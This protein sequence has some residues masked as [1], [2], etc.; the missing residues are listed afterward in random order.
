MVRTIRKLSE[1]TD[2][3]AFE[4]LATAIL[5]EARPEYA[6]LLHPGVNLAGKTVKAP[7]DGIGFVP[8]AEPPHMIAA[9]HTTC[10]RD[11]LFKK[12]LHDPATVKPR[13]GSRPTMPAGDL[14][15]TAE[16]VATEKKRDPTLRATLVLTTNREPPEDL[17]RETHAA[18][19][20]RGIDVDIWSVSRL[21]HALDTPSGQWLRRQFL[22]IEQERLS[23]ELLAK[24]SLDSLK[25]HRPNDD[26]TAWVSRAL[27]RVIADAVQE[28]TVVFIIAESGLGKSVACYKR[29]EQHVAAGGFGLILPHQVIA[30]ALTIEQAIEATIRQLYPHLAAG[31]ELDVLSFCSADRPLVLVVEDINKSGQAPLLAE[32][33]AKWSSLG[34][35]TTTSE[36]TAGE[37]PDRERWRLLCPIWPHVAASLSDAT[38]KQVQRLAAMGAVF[39]V[40]EGREAV[41]RRAKSKGLFLSDLD[42]DG[43]SEAL[44][45]DPLFIALHEPGQRP[46]PE[47]VI[48]QFI[49][50]SVARLSIDLGEYTASDYRSALRSM[51]GVMLSHRELSPS[52]PALLS[53]LDGDSDI[54]DMLRHLVHCGEIIRLTG[55]ASDEHLAFRHDRVR[56]ALFSDAIAAMIRSGTLSDGLLAEPYFA[57]VIGAA[58]LYD[59][60]PTAIVDRVHATNPLAL[61]HTLRVF[62]EP[63]S[64]IQQ[65]VLAAIDLWLADPKTHAL[66]YSH[67]RL[68]AL[69]ALS[70]TES[71]KV[72]G[73]VRKF[74]DTPWTAWQALFR[75]G[76]LA[77]GLH[78]CL[79]LAPGVGSIWRDQQIDHAKM[80]FG[81]NLRT[82]V[83]RILRQTSPAEGMLI[84]ALR[85]AGYLADPQLAEAIE[86]SW[87]LDPEKGNHLEDYLWASAECCGSDPDR[88]LGSV[89]DA[90]AA[91]PTDKN[92]NM[93][94]ARD[95]LAAHTVRW[96]F[97][98]DVP[99]SAVGYFIKRA[100]AEDLRWPITYMLHGLDHPDAVEFVVRELAETDRR[101]EGTESFSPFS[102]TAT[103]EWQRRQ[104]DKGRPMS[105]ESR[106]R[107][108]ALWQNQANDKYVR[109]QAFRFWA[110]TES[111]GDLEILRSMD[112][113]D[114]LADS[115]LWQRLRRK[116][117]TA[118][119]GLLDKLKGD[120]NERAHWW[121]LGHLIWSDELTRAL[122][123]E[124]NARSASVARAWDAKFETDYATYE[125]IMALPA[126]QAEVLL[127]KNWDHLRFRDLFVQAAL[128]VATPRMLN[129]VKDAVATCPNP[130]GLFKYLHMHFG[131]RTIG[132]AGVTRTSQ[133]EAL[134]PYLD[135]LDELTIYMFWEL[136]N[137]RGWFDL[138]RKLFDGRISNKYAGRFYLEEDQIVASLDEMVRDKNLYWI[139]R[140]FED[141]VQ[142][143][144]TAGQV[145]SI[146]GKWLRAQKTFEAL[147]LAAMALIHAGRR[148]D[149]HVLNVAIE[150][151]DEADAL[152]ADTAF[153]VKRRSLV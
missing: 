128:Y 33:L 42:A 32:K 147:R 63:R 111:D 124:L 71:S 96:A 69:A 53:W 89:C 61:F 8:S 110:A 129:L 67:L 82:A 77:G 51:A 99:M 127:V 93:P 6:S 118:I 13:K 16:I 43:I 60:I 31:A 23:E 113:S 41:Q 120:G 72:V 25:I 80:R 22:G 79:N 17:V 135:H 2:E 145:I 39:T 150:P 74:K 116:D 21:A 14:I 153:A 137:E 55:T 76:D 108:L 140:W 5:R 20:A 3:A 133:I 141:Y 66:L 98:K 134:I 112:T 105:R 54:P 30:S 123:G 18:G 122:E 62:R 117:H 7:V 52:W 143:G 46:Q 131:I 88:F 58:L 56:D 106:E 90:W 95:N 138:R 4:R 9:H 132:R 101:L 103:D 144:A 107:L 149:L 86:A 109:R 91:L 15:K 126:A 28:Q 114:L 11:Y 36:D 136:C 57:E 38:R 119:P 81:S 40:P 1:M 130:K 94:S 19:Q 24:L 34:N 59:G 97:H 64:S 44:G 35:A 70:R 104:E 146:I 26:P 49:D 100:K 121:R 65:A 50:T 48:E 115:V 84:G 85:L 29:L 152:L 12:W 125:L 142:T 83:D 10:K 73:L 92:N 151:K 75:N 78:L 27:D 37:R 68:E 139:D 47:R 87:N 102:L 45:H 148:Q